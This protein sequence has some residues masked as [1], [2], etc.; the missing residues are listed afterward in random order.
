MYVCVHCM[1]LHAT[2]I[3]DND[4]NNIRPIVFNMKKVSYACFLSTCLLSF[5]YT[6]SHRLPCPGSPPRH[7]HLLQFSW[8]TPAQLHEAIPKPSSP[9]SP[10]TPPR[11]ATVQHF[12]PTS[13]SCLRNRFGSRGSADTASG[14]LARNAGRRRQLSV[15]PT[16]QCSTA[17]HILPVEEKQRPAT[18]TPPNLFTPI[19]STQ[20][21]FHQR[22]P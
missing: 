10:P 22:D 4:N 18:E 3:Q 14:Q 13:N 15:V 2:Y 6:P 20:Y 7:N 17:Q 19:R 9:P 1:F 5:T 16:Q 11:T 8:Y 12:P 21:R